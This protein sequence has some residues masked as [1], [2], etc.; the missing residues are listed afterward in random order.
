M[1]LLHPSFNLYLITDRK[2]AARHGGLAAAV[3]AALSA[4]STAA[5][6]G[7]VAVQLREK[8]LEAREL[9][10]QG[11]VMRELCSRYHAPLLINDRVDVALAINADGMHLRT[12]SIYVR[13]A[14]ELLGPSRLIGVSTHTADEVADAAREGA[15]FV[16]F[17]PVYPPLSKPASGVAGGAQ[18][19]SAACHAASGM[20]VFALGGITPARIGDLAGAGAL[21]ERARP[22]GVAVIG[23]VFAADNPAAATCDL[24]EALARLT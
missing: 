21:F 1:A 16:V 10:E 18:A 20:P 2:L 13:D 19:L 23:S 4:A 17:G 11:C 3:E 8:D 9:Y 22:S 7:A 12:D 24:L 14:R 5:A 15:D 6:P